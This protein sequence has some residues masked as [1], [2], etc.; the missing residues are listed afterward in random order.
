VL[1]SQYLKESGKFPA[2]NERRREFTEK[3]LAENSTVKNALLLMH[4]PLF[5]ETP[6]EDDSLGSGKHRPYESRLPTLIVS[7][8][9]NQAAKRRLFPRNRSPLKSA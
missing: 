4:H 6:D 7:S 9:K 8:I 3:E 1:N 5:S 2:E